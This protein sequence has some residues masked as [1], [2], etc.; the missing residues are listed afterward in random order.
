MQ[1]T[2]LDHLPED[3]FNYLTQYRNTFGEYVTC[4]DM[5]EHN[6]LKLDSYLHITSPIRRLV[7]L[8]NMIVI[9]EKMGFNNIVGDKARLF[10]ENWSSKL[11]YINTTM[12][13]I[14]KVQNDC[15]LLSLFEEVDNREQLYMGYV[16][17]RIQ[18]IDGQYQYNV[19]IPKLRMNSRLTCFDKYENYTEHNIHL[20]M[21]SS[22]FNVKK[23]IKAN[24]IS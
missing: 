10:Y 24:I 22:E 7:D 1:S 6:H 9:H 18:R 11:Q 2:G 20:Y 23:K 17:D 15:R 8:L 13:A 3:V 4:K 19:Y 12:R 14:R 16:F 5:T 21:F